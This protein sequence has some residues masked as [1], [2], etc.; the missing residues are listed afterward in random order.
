MLFGDISRTGWP[1]MHVNAARWRTKRSTLTAEQL[2]TS[3]G[4]K[5]REEAGLPFD[6]CGHFYE[7]LGG[8]E[9]LRT[10]ASIIF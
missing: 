7:R 10:H 3:G 1:R 5:K 2:G 6:S 8:P 9:T 4:I